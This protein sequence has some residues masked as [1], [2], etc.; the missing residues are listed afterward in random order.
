MIQMDPEYL[1]NMVQLSQEMGI[2]RE[3]RGIISAKMRYIGIVWGQVYG[4]AWDYM[5]EKGIGDCLE[6]DWAL[7]NT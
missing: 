4:I 5:K 1:A 7:K 3:T 2:I 6:L